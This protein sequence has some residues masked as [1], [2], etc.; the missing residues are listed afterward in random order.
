MTIET[1][2]VFR[3]KKTLFPTQSVVFLA[4][5]PTPQRRVA[6]PRLGTSPRFRRLRRVGVPRERQLLTL[7]E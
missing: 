3:S 2:S 1:E 7:A 5:D 4:S 6:P